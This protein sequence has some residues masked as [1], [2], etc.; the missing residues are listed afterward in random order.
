MGVPGPIAPAACKLTD[1]L[2]PYHMNSCIQIAG[3]MKFG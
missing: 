3:V 2:T 1:L